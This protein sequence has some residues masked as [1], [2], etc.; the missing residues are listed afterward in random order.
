MTLN[1]SISRMWDELL[2]DAQPQT[3]AEQE[4]DFTGW[5]RKEISDWRMARMDLNAAAAALARLPPAPA[6]PA[7]PPELFAAWS[8]RDAAILAERAAR[9]AADR[10]AEHP[11][12]A[13][14]QINAR[15]TRAA[16]DKAAR[17][18]EAAE[19][20]AEEAKRRPPPVENPDAPGPGSAPAE[21][22]AKPKR[23]RPPA[24]KPEP[25]PEPKQW[26]EERAHWR[27]R[28]PLEEEDAR[29][30][31][32]M[33]RCLVDYDPIEYFLKEQRELAERERE[34]KDYDPF[35]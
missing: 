25:A 27:K 21:A 22:K 3:P 31:R 26:W 4:P 32:P 12:S 14:A 13:V 16:A 24:P 29:R 17:A 35:R 34:D 6:E 5:T 1:R 2:Q 20:L 11:G 8:A 15:A 28:S 23:R 10:L 19:R 7:D 18:A 30:G 33:Y 9:A